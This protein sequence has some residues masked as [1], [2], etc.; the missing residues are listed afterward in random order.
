MACCWYW[1]PARECISQT[2][3]QT[4]NARKHSKSRLQ[5][6]SQFATKFNVLQKFDNCAKKKIKTRIALNPSLKTFPLHKSVWSHDFSF[7]RCSPL[8][9][10]PKLLLSLPGIAAVGC[11]YIDV[12]AP[13]SWTLPRPVAKILQYLA[14]AISPP[15]PLLSFCNNTPFTPA[16]HLKSTRSWGKISDIISGNLINRPI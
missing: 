11:F 16:C 12:A 7:I 9:F 5:S 15:P 1:Q 14:P 6:R 3:V 2:N 10:I 4:L 8:N 13:S